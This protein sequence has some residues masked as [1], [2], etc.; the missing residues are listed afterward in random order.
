VEVE[1]LEPFL[2]GLND[3]KSAARFE[4]LSTYRFS[5][6]IKS[7]KRAIAYIDSERPPPSLLKSQPIPRRLRL[8]QGAERI[9]V[10]RYRDIF[11][12]LIDDL[13]YQHS[14]W[15]AF[16][17]LSRGVQEARTV[18]YRHRRLQTVAQRFADLM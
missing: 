4:A 10:L 16:V 18:S 17:E 5:D 14:L 12:R 6:P 1:Q 8:D 9:I 15:T 3:L 13:E 2:N 11:W 7:P